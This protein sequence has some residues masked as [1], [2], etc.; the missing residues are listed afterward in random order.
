MWAAGDLH[1]YQRAHRA[2]L[3]SPRAMAKVLLFLAGAVPDPASR[4]P[5]RWKLIDNEVR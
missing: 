4:L 2:L 3:S 5:P 1:A